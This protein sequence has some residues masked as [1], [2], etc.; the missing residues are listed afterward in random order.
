MPKRRLILLVL[1]CGVLA[2]VLFPV[3]SRPHEPSY[4]GRPLS[5]W[6]EMSSPIT[7]P[8]EREQARVAIHQMGTNAIPSLLKAIGYQRPAWKEALLNVAERLPYAGELESWLLTDKALSRADAARDAFEELGP[9]AKGAVRD[10]A[11]LMNTATSHAT[12]HRAADA[13]ARLGPDACPFLFEAL[14]NRQISGRVRALSSISYLG[15]HARPVV[16]LLV[17]FLDDPDWT[18]RE[19][20]A[21]ALGRLKLDGFLVV[22]ALQTSLSDSDDH[23]RRGA[24]YALG[25]Y[26]QEARPAVPALLWLIKDP[27]ALVREEA[28]NAIVVIAPETLT[29]T[30]PP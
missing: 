18:V 30:T 25:E 1:A 12:G 13:L 29:N 26:G 2:V 28:T 27:D 20:A 11:R 17:R 7:P 6:L 15:A 3:L 9:E 5:H 21:F 16:P 19:S 10:L 4:S 8:H 22:P 23:V 14:T 24:A